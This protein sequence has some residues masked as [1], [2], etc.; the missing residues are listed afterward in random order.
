[1]LVEQEKQLMAVEILGQI[2]FFQVLHLLVVD[3]VPLKLLVEMEV[4]EEEV[5]AVQLEDQ[6]IHLLSVHLKDKMVEQH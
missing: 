6:V 5:E 2:Q 1:M 3:S 4:L